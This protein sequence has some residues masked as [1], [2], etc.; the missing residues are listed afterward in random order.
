MKRKVILNLPD[1]FI[2]TSELLNV[3][4]EKT[5]ETIIKS[6]KIYDFI[7]SD[8]NAKRSLAKELFK[9][10]LRTKG[11]DGE[12]VMREMSHANG[13]IPC[14]QSL[15]KIESGVK[16]LEY[17]A[18]MKT[19]L[20]EIYQG[21]GTDM[22]E[23]SMTIGETFCIKTTA[24]FEVLCKLFQVDANA[25]LQ[26]YI[27]RISLPEMCSGHP[28]DP[29]GILME[30]FQEYTPSED[31]AKLKKYLEKKLQGTYHYTMMTIVKADN[32]QPECEA[33]LRVEI[34]KWRDEYRLLRREWKKQ[35]KSLNII[36]YGN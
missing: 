28:E 2:L 10:F 15:V 17:K 7:S 32:E 9:R 11:V 8:A 22:T 29:K 35:G 19:W 4:L 5:L 27:N 6:L 34:A 31:S 33:L 25:F 14:I 36:S 12:R 16:A 26:Y 30:F 21:S 1:D 18:T 24:D 20:Q 3:S 13:Y 23:E